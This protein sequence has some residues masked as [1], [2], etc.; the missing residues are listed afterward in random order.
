MADINKL[1]VFQ[2]A[3]EL[4]RMV[5]P[6]T[7]RVAFGDL[8]NQIRRAAISVASNICEGAGSGSDRQFARYCRLARA[9][10]NEA[11]G[12]L[13]IL[14]DLGAIDGDHPAIVLSDRIGRRLSCLI[15]RL[16]PG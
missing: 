15:K 6:I 11:Q 13:Q 14:G 2:E 3:R 16:E 4:V 1:I 8:G 10:V 7:E 5:H 9:S 12:Q